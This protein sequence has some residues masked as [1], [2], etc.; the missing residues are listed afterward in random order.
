MLGP[1]AAPLIMPMCIHLGGVDII[2]DYPHPA[3]LWIVVTV[4][5]DLNSPKAACCKGFH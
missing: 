4:H 2:C 5:C 1:A 3:V